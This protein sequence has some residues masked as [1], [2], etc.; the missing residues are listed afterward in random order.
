MPSV[1]LTP[2]DCIIDVEHGLS[3]KASQNLVRYHH[4]IKFPNRDMVITGVVKR[5]AG[6]SFMVVGMTNAG[7][8]LYKARVSKDSHVRSQFWD[9]KSVFKMRETGIKNTYDAGVNKGHCEI[10]KNNLGIPDEF[11][12]QNIVGDIKL[13]YLECCSKCS[14]C[15]QQEGDLDTVWLKDP[16]NNNAFFVL[17]D[18]T[19]GYSKIR[20]DKLI[21]QAQFGIGNSRRLESIT[22]DNLDVGYKAVIKV[23]KFDM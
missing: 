14:Q 15:Y 7:T 4:S 19:L 11:L 21:Y 8:T 23:L 5:L 10:L 20:D 17:T 3:L 16:D 13:L 22:I 2:C 12:I 9:D 18:G 6:D 1:E